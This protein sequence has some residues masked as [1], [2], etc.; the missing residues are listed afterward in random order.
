MLRLNILSSRMMASNGLAFSPI[1]LPPS[2]S[3]PKMFKDDLGGWP[4]KPP[5]VTLFLLYL[6]KIN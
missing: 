2:L 6:Q 1:G 5:Q 3:T 4:P